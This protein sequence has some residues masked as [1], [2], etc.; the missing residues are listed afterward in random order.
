MDTPNIE[1]WARLTL[2]EFLHEINLANIFAGLPDG[3]D[4]LAHFGREIEQR[5]T[6]AA[7]GLSLLD[8][9]QRDEWVVN[10][11]TICQRFFAKAEARRAELARKRSAGA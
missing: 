9:E 2:S 10:A 7:R 3:Q 6:Q 5:M 4:A 1:S 8:A 11:A